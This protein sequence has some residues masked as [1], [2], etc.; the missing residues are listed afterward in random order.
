MPKLLAR[1]RVI[2]AEFAKFGIVGA[3]C[4]VVDV[5][6]FNVFH[7]GLDIDPLLAKTASVVI[8][9]T[10]SYLGNRHWSFRHRARTGFRRE[11]ALFFG[12]NGVGLA[13][14][15][16]CLAFT[17]YALGLTGPLALNVAGNVIGMGMATLF[18][19]WSYRRWV[20]PAAPSTPGSAEPVVP[21]VAPEAVLA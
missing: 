19:F 8:A 17:K 16:G 5:G 6:L 4:T 1:F 21:E 15:L 18:R 11:Y 20:F 13:L 14:A 7:F 2:G 10:V 3:V 9:V 12:L